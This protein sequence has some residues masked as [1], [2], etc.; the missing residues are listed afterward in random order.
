MQMSARHC[1]IL[2]AASCVAACENQPT[3]PSTS[4]IPTINASLAALSSQ[5]VLSA[6]VVVHVRDADSV[7]ARFSLVDVPSSIDSFTP[8][9]KIADDSAVIPVLGLLP[10]HRYTLRA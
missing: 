8:A 9:I 7:A 10:S 6:I 4:I 3:V 1:R 2:I 5:N